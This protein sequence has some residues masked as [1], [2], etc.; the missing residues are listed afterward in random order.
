MDDNIKALLEYLNIPGAGKYIVTP[1]TFYLVEGSWMIAPEA[2]GVRVTNTSGT[3]KLRDLKAYALL[4]SVIGDSKHIV[5]YMEQVI[6]SLIRRVANCSMSNFILVYDEDESCIE[7][8]GYMVM[9]MNIDGEESQLDTRHVWRIDTKAETLHR[10][11]PIRWMLE[12][13]TWNV[14]EYYQDIAG[15]LILLNVINNR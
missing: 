8:I 4:M 14:I 13:S 2:D 6:E 11:A 15:C 3:H 12:S 10:Y 7:V 1:T 5:P 9:H